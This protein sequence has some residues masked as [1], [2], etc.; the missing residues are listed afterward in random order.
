[1]KNWHVIAW[2]GDHQYIVSLSGYWQDAKR[3]DNPMGRV[4]NTKR[5]KLYLPIN[6]HSLFSKQAGWEEIT[7][8][9]QQQ[10]QLLLD[11]LDVE[12]QQILTPL[13][14]ALVAAA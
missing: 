12:T 4:L 5:R 8:S 1:M 14:P 10:E 7:V 11:V 2:D 3:L 9:A 13:T 6:L